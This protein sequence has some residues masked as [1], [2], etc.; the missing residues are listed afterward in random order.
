M[1]LLVLSCD[2]TPPSGDQPVCV[3]RNAGMANHS[4]K[5][6]VYPDGGTR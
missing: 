6:W 5:R 3:E 4:C 2:R 1:L